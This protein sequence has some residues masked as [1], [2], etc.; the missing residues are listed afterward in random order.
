MC[1]KDAADLSF[2]PQGRFV[3][4]LLTWKI[5]NEDHCTIDCVKADYGFCFLLLNKYAS[6]NLSDHEQ[7]ALRIK[8]LFKK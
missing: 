2:G 3:C 7:I 6:L 8:M 4:V 1:P 5:R